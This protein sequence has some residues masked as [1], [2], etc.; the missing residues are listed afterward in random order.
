MLK[1]FEDYTIYEGVIE[2]G[3]IG[4]QTMDTVNEGL[5]DKFMNMF[6]NIDDDDELWKEF[7][8]YDNTDDIVKGMN[9]NKKITNNLLKMLKQKRDLVVKNGKYT[10]P[11]YDKTESNLVLK[12]DDKRLSIPVKKIESDIEKELGKIPDPKE[13]DEFQS[14]Y[15][16]LSAHNDVLIGK[17]VEKEWDA[18]DKEKFDTNILKKKPIKAK[19]EK[20]KKETENAREEKEEKMDDLLDGVI[21]SV[22]NTES[23]NKVEDEKYFKV[24]TKNDD[25]E[26]FDK[27]LGNIKIAKKSAISD[28]FSDKANELYWALR[29]YDACFG[30]DNARHIKHYEDNEDKLEDI[31]RFYLSMILATFSCFEYVKGS[32]SDGDINMKDNKLFGMTPEKIKNGTNASSGTCVSDLCVVVLVDNVAKMVKDVNNLKSSATKPKEKSQCA[33][34]LT[35]FS[36][37]SEFLKNP[38]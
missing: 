13:R 2:S 3:Y 15:E 31:K 25:P 14:Y 7:V 12:Y 10:K 29:L 32:K 11:S 20:V 9:S 19:I 16:L 27:L 33:K 34:I 35:L 17:K 26:V 37:F 18:E 30:D 28:A 38:K 21:E 23:I 4:R 8:S 36:K 5:L 22:P 24:Y 1:T 6:R